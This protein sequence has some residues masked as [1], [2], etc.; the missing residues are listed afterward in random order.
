VLRAIK[1]PRAWIS[2]VFLLIASSALAQVGIGM[3]PPRFELTLE[4]G[5]TVSKDVAIFSRNAPDQRISVEIVDWSLSPDGRLLVLPRGSQRYSAANWLSAAIDPFT[6]KQNEPHI[7]HFSVTAPATNLEGSY[8]AGL[9]FTTQPN[10]GKHK[11]M[12]VAVRTRAVV[13]IYVTIQGTEKPASALQGLS[14][15]T[16]EDGKNYIVADVVNKGNVYL[17]LNGELRFLNTKGEV[18]ERTPLTERVLLREGLV[19]Y[20]LPVP[21]DLPEDVLLAAIEIRPQGPSESYGGPPLYGEIP[22]R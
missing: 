13:I 19:R 4:P 10:P 21:E 5:A 20:K 18:V 7:I 12:V 22:L 16:E 3:A 11:G 8:W 14:L 2:G 1:N 9:S 6:L 15:Q 17:R